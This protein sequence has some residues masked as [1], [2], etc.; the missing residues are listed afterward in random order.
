MQKRLIGV[1]FAI[2]LVLPWTFVSPGVAALA[3][4]DYLHDTILEIKNVTVPQEPLVNGTMVSM[5]YFMRQIDKANQIL[6]GT[7]T[8]NYESQQIGRAHV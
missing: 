1:F 7:A 2:G 4:V 5:K 6:N 3:S 8:T